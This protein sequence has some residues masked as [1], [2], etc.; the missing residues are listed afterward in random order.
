M[1]VGSFLFRR[2]RVEGKRRQGPQDLRDVTVMSAILISKGNSTC[3][4]MC[5]HIY[6]G[7]RIYTSAH[8]CGS[9]MSAS[10]V[11]PQTMFTLFFET[12]CLTGI[13]D[14]PV[15]LGRLSSRGRGLP[16]TWS[17]NMPPLPAFTLLLGIKL[18]SSHLGRECFTDSYLSTLQRKLFRMRIHCVGQEWRQAKG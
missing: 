5:V 3:E 4:C 9:Q 13:R 6:A 2:D 1:C 14:S 15:K 8:G 18:R 12:R 7:V 16:S 17:A 11:L 10:G